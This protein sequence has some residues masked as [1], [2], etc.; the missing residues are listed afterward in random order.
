MPI[1]IFIS[2]RGPFRLRC[3]KRSRAHAGGKFAVS[4]L[5]LTAVELV[6]SLGVVDELH[7][8][9]QEV[10]FRDEEMYTSSSANPIVIDTSE[11]LN[12]NCPL[13]C[14]AG[15]FHKNKHQCVVFYLRLFKA[16]LLWT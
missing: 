2:H 7:Y 3:L 9:G 15:L 14:E 5:R 13:S 16:C 1:D 11:I 10:C 8:H 6:G 12:I 4:F